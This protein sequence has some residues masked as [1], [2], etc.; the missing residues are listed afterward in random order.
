MCGRFVR[1]ASLHDISDEFGVAETSVVQKPSFNISPG[2]DIAMVINDGSKRLIFCQWGFVPA[3]AKGPPFS[4][5]LINARAETV[6]R[7]PSFR[8]AYKNRRG[9]IIADGFY[10]WQS[11]SGHR[12][13]YYIHLRSGKPFGMAG[14]YNSW[15]SPDGEKICTCTIITTEANSLIKKIHGRMPVIIRKEKENL[16]LNAG[17]TDHAL[18]APLLLPYDSDRMDAHEVSTAVNTPGVDRPQNISPIE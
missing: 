14:L 4:T 16:W 6:N 13:P 17:I 7:K 10:E 12:K 1:K 15:N 9:L 11:G 3:W 8:N 18:L 5:R 2:H